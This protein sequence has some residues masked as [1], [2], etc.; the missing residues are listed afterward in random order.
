MEKAS[1][2]LQAHIQWRLQMFP[3]NPSSIIHELRKG[4]CFV[5]GKDKA[6]HPVIY[7]FTRKQ[8]PKERKVEDV[9]KM[10]VY[11]AEQAIWMMPNRTG[12]VTVLFIREGDCNY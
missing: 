12:K 2:Q 5:R 10:L 1:I 7:Y 6:G 8:D 3:L 11:R 4:K 9:I